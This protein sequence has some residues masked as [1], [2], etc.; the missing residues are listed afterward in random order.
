M[1]RLTKSE[2]MIVV[3]AIA[4]V[5]LPTDIIPEVVAGPLGL[6]DDVGAL[7]VLATTLW[8]ARRR[9]PVEQS[10]PDEEDEA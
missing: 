3:L 9:P 8:H 2:W 1:S 5:I 10:Q 6:T 4:Y 7:A